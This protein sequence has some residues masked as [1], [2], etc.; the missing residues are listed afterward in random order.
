MLDVNRCLFLT[1]PNT[2]KNLVEAPQ[3]PNSIIFAQKLETVCKIQPFSVQR[4]ESKREAETD[5]R[6]M[7]HTLGHSDIRVLIH[8]LM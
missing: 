8:A 2:V 7:L 4:N 1:S 5:I 6:D 3:P